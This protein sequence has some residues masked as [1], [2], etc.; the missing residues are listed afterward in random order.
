MGFR[1]RLFHVQGDFQVGESVIDF[2]AAGGGRELALGS[3]WTTQT[4]GLS[5]EKRLRL[6][7]EAA[8]QFNNGVAGP[9][10]L[11]KLE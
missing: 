3:L 10:V 6:A 1:K 9:V 4:F 8:E 11:E 7:I 2:D 5:P